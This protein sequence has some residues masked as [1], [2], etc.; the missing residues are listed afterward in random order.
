MFG[1]SRTSTP[2]RTYSKTT[3]R[4]DG[5]ARSRRVTVTP[6]PHSDQGPTVLIDAV[7]EASGMPHLT[8]RGCRNPGRE[9]R[10]Y[11]RGL[12]RDG[13]ILVAE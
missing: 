11:G 13:Y 2:S 9:A 3:V 1:K 10:R 5:I 12:V 4:L 7:D 6:A 8:R